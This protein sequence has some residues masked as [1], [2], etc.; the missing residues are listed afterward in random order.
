MG[1]T[2]KSISQRTLRDDSVKS[3]AARRWT[4]AS[5]PC[6]WMLRPRC[7]ASLCATLRALSSFGNTDA[8]SA[9]ASK[10]PRRNSRSVSAKA[11]AAAQSSSPGTAVAIGIDPTV[12]GTASKDTVKLL[13]PMNRRMLFADGGGGFDVSETTPSSGSK[14]KKE[15]WV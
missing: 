5:A 6:L 2:G 13:S 11:E 12:V 10:R 9:G 7:G 3:F 14:N 1:V 15:A 8:N 4:Y